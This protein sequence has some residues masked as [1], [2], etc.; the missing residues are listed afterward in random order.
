LHPILGRAYVAPNFEDRR[1]QY[2][3]Y[4]FIAYGFPLIRERVG[5]AVRPVVVTTPDEREDI[6]TCFLVGN[7]CTLV[8][9]RHVVDGMPRVKIPDPPVS[10]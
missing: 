6:G 10:G 9:A 5:P 1:A 4:D 7:Q 8:T 2:G 3:E